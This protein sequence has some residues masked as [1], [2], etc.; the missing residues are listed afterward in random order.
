MDN[1]KKVA[2]ITGSNRG[3]GFETAKQLGEKGITVIVTGRNQGVADETAAKLKASGINAFGIQLDVTNPSDRK[4]AAAFINEKF[5]KLDILINNAGVGPKGD[6]FVNKAVE[7]DEEEFQYVFGTNVFSL[8]YITNELLPLLKASGYARIVNLSSLLGSLGTHANPNGPFEEV[9]RLSYNASK[10]ALNAVTIHLAAE[11]KKF[12]IKVN[13]ADPGHAK[14][15]MG[16][17]GAPMEISDGARTS[18]ELALIGEDGPTGKFIH[19]GEER[20]W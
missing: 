15:D 11:L 12:G 13:S 7:T 5:G 2:L 16:G 14:T 1:Q 6:F 18:V 3:L 20:P 9:K 17:A 4:A 19:L 10:T 8:V